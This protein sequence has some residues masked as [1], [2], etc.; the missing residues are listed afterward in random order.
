[1]MRKAEEINILQN[2]RTKC[3]EIYYKKS[4]TTN[5]EELIYICFLCFKEFYDNTFQEH[6][7]EEHFKSKS[8]PEKSDD[9]III[10]DRNDVE[11][12]EIIEMEP[13]FEDIIEEDIIELEDENQLKMDM[14]I[15]IFDGFLIEKSGSLEEM[16]SCAANENDTIEYA[17]DNVQIQKDVPVFTIDTNHNKEEK[18][19]TEHDL[20]VKK[21]CLFCSHLM[22]ID[23]LDLHIKRV[24][25]NCGKETQ[26]CFE[27]SES[28]ND[29]SVWLHHRTTMHANK[30]IKPY[31]QQSNN[32]ENLKFTTEK[33]TNDQ[34]NLLAKP[35]EPPKNGN[36]KCIFC[37]LSFTPNS[38][39]SHIT[40]RH[41]FNGLTQKC[42]HCDELLDSW[43]NWRKHQYNAHNIGNDLPKSIILP[44]KQCWFCT[45]KLSR[46]SII[47]HMKRRHF[48]NNSMQK[49]I[50]CDEKFYSWS[51]IKDHCKMTH[52]YDYDDENTKV[53]PQQQRIIPIVKNECNIDPTT[54]EQF[55]KCIN[56]NQIFGSTV[57]MKKHLIGD[58]CKPI[59]P[60]II[61]LPVKRYK[62]NQCPRVFSERSKYNHHLQWHKSIKPK[63]LK[64]E[65]FNGE[66][67][68][69]SC[70]FCQKLFASKINLLA[71][72]KMGCQLEKLR[73]TCTF[74]HHKTFFTESLKKHLK[75]AHFNRKTKLDTPKKCAHQ[76]DNEMVNDILLEDLSDCLDHISK[77]HM[78]LV[79][80]LISTSMNDTCMECKNGFNCYGKEDEHFELVH[81]IRNPYKCDKCS[82]NFETETFLIDHE[83]LHNHDN[84]P[85][86]KYC[87]QIFQ[88]QLDLNLH[89][90][91]SIK[92]NEEF[93]PKDDF[94]PFTMYKCKHCRRHYNTQRQLDIH[95]KCHSAPYKCKVC[96]RGF[97]EA[98]LFD[99][100]MKA[101]EY[102]KVNGK[103]YCNECAY[104]TFRMDK[105]QL[106]MTKHSDN[107][108][109]FACE[110]CDKTFCAA[111]YLTV[112]RRLHTNEF[113]KLC[114]L[115]GK[116][117]YLNSKYKI[118]MRKH[119]GTE[120][121]FK[122]EICPKT[123]SSACDLNA[124]FC[125]HTG[126]RPFE[127]DRGCG[128]L[129]TAH[130]YMKRHRCSLKKELMDYELDLEDA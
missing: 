76:H 11:Y 110:I 25:F 87:N 89:I 118:H 92:M 32:A 65:S 40:R 34:R 54:S 2:V 72:M 8:K 52:V 4:E 107:E 59:L 98:K 61:K 69:F 112:H 99:N 1:M 128:K 37:E 36:K 105:F 13:S 120:R 94:Q 30:E 24:H 106:H 55:P 56:C 12:L 85:T 73:F 9:K 74:C 127:C 101:H 6:I 91:G 104:E 41:F 31:D 102:E 3:G 79:T 83:E 46:N 80:E 75:R 7:F 82:A 27:C 17:K 68:L 103:Y 95:I 117:F 64:Q 21:R 33:D 84:L 114:W 93:N 62:C 23:T 39:W 130:K 100:H 126:D 109:I 121:R 116:S 96:S 35:E 67:L 20:V 44:K 45:I 113:V 47:E 122:C 125:T 86:C 129:F 50:F 43:T 57:A 15:E 115:C 29:Y 48:K 22:N 53:L 42:F 18:N 58:S 66:I 19:D 28:F 119:D 77:Y 10:D 16:S 97:F 111:S 14:N 78:E 63:I 71:H 81:S 88:C 123:F 51:K 26:Q 60:E 124:H 5:G 108:T 70:R 49:C 38:Y 90:S